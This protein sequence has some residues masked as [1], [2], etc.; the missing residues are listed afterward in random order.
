[1]TD[2]H[3]LAIDAGNSYVKLG[4]FKEEGLVRSE[5]IVSSPASDHNEWTA[6]LRK[7]LAG[8]DGV[9]DIC[10]GCVVSSVT[11]QN[12]VA[13]LTALRECGLEPILEISAEVYPHR[14][15]YE[16]PTQL[17]VDRLCDAAG[18]FQRAR[19]AVIVVD[20]GTA[21]T[22]NAVS[23]E[24]DFLGGAIAPGPVIAVAALAK[25]T[26]QLPEIRAAF[27]PKTIGTSTESNLAS[28]LTHGWVAMVDGLIQRM[29]SEMGGMVSVLATGGAGAEFTKQSRRIEY[30]HPYLTLEGAAAIYR[31]WKARN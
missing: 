29:E 27:P 26:A 12:S 30:Y 6:R 4:L 1:M 17:G 13:I 15:L 25:G 2:I 19:G 11:P 18:G 22:F 16:N 21:V 8:R 31:R 14:V 9:V 20:F 23:A 10:N 28:G 24:G 5:R 3:F 7:F